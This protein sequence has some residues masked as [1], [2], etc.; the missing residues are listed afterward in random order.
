MAAANRL[1]KMH[2]ACN[3]TQRELHSAVCRPIGGLEEVPAIL[4][5]MTQ[6]GNE[7]QKRE[8]E[9]AE[10]LQSN[11]VADV[12][13]CSVLLFHSLDVQIIHSFIQDSR[14][15]YNQGLHT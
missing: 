5:K 8:R 12:C 6:R 9:S 14:I 10:L 2:I 7:V 3:S 15:E 11:D 1:L 13:N 4:T